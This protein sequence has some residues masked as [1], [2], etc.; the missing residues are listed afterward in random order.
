MLLKIRNC[1]L[2]VKRSQNLDATIRK[3]LVSITK[4]LSQPGK[5][6]LAA[7]ESPGNIGKKLASIKAENTSENRRQFRQ[8]L[9]TTKDIGIQNYC[10][11]ITFFS[12]SIYFFRELHFRNNT[13]RF[14]SFSKN[15]FW[16]FLSTV[17]CKSW[18]STWD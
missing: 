6:I 11:C 2:I 8:L 9:F 16:N 13:I 1:F 14:Y 3:E 5:G 17:P 7:D 4:K 15:R 10:T 12:K 18:N